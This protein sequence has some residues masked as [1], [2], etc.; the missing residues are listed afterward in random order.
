MISFNEKFT[1]AIPTLFPTEVPLIT[2]FWTTSSV[3]QEMKS[4]G[5]IVFN[6][7]GTGADTIDRTKKYLK[8]KN[9]ELN[10]TLVVTARWEGIISS[11]S[12]VPVWY[13]HLITV[14]F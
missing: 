9:I 10:V 6:D 3:E 12:E 4:W 8:S 1:N 13:F 14:A 2:A 11:I 5:Y 7:N